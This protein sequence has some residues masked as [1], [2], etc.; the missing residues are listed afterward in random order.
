MERITERIDG[1]AK[2][3]D[4]YQP[5]EENKISFL[6]EMLELHEEII[7]LLEK[8]I[9]DIRLSYTKGMFEIIKKELP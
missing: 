6:L 4:E 2:L 9:N 3:K 8:Q 7:D 5:L 1:I